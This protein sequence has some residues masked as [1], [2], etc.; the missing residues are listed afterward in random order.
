M[1]ILL[2]IL[3]ALILIYISYKIWHDF[4]HDRKINFWRAVWLV[5]IVAYLVISNL[6]R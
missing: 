4:V 1:H 2:S 6:K 5:G 3:L